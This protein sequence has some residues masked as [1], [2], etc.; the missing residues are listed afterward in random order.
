MPFQSF[1]EHRFPKPGVGG[2][3]PAGET[4]VFRV[5]L[6]VPVS[7]ETRRTERPSLPILAT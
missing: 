2:S 3:F 1:I 6:D 5:I 4:T 7:R